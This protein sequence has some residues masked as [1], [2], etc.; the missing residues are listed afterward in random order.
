MHPILRQRRHLALYLLAWFPLA[1]LLGGALRLAGGISWGQALAV[2][3]PACVVLAFICLASWYIVRAN[4]IGRTSVERILTALGAGAALS[5][6]AWLGLIWLAIGLIAH[7]AGLTG[8]TVNWSGRQYLVLAVGGV[9]LYLLAAAFHYLLASLEESRRAERR[10]L[11]LDLLSRETE[12]KLLR[13]QID[14]H[15]LFNALNSIAA[16][17]H[18][19]PDRARRMC[20]GLGDFFRQSLRLGGQKHV[21]LAEELNLARSFL[22]IEQIR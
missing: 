1:A 2:A 11:E 12:L 4:P 18:S 5:A 14:P 6:A 22:A 9:F 16:L 8:L 17:T 10:L 3:A 7:T 13:A 21:R 20:T 15:F 19:D